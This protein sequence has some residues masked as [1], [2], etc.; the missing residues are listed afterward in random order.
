MEN[1]GLDKK[2]YSGAPRECKSN[3]PD[4]VDMRPLQKW[5][6]DKAKAKSKRTRRI[7]SEKYKAFLEDL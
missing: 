7:L 1:I 2:A 5:N 6:W 3:W 4:W